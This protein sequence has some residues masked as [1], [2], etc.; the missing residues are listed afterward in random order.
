MPSWVEIGS[1]VLEKKILKFHQCIFAISSFSPLGK[2]WGLSFDYTWIP[3]IQKWF[4]SSLVEICPVF[5]RRFLS[6][7]FVNEFVPISLSSLEKGQGPSFEQTWILF[8][9]GCF[10][11]SLVKFGLQILE[12]I[13]SN[14]VDV[15]LLFCY[16][17]MF[18]KDKTLHFKTLESP[19][20]IH[21]DAL[22]QVWLKL[23]QWFL[24]R[25]S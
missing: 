12:K 4:L 25:I 3:I 20:H 7:N 8:T 23:A 15:F 22:C 18:K 14:F 5:R 2:G 17:P 21:V 1:M 6:V 19:S 11:Q 10:V 16:F 13:H 24:R 9:Q